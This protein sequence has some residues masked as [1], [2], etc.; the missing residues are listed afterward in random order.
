MPPLQWRDRCGSSNKRPPG[1]RY[2]GEF[3]F[4]L[5]LP[6]DKFAQCL[7]FYR[8]A[9]DAEIVEIAPGVANVFVFGAQITFHDRPTSSGT[10]ANRDD[11][12]FGSI[13]MAD[14]WHRIRDRLVGRGYAL[15][16]SVA[17]ADAPGGR[18]KLLLKDPGGSLVEINSEPPK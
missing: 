6:V 5:S 13:V 4:H 17:H 8:S 11:M 14:E 15:I 2:S 9:F 12:H 10:Y 18:A 16:K 3:V 1:K 7:E